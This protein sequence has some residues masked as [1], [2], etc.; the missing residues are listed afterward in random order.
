VAHQEAQVQVDLQEQ[1]EV[2]VHQEHQVL[3]GHQEQVE[4]LDHQEHQEQVVL[5]EHP[6]VVVRQGLLVH[7]EQVG[8]HFLQ[9]ELVLLILIILLPVQQIKQYTIQVYQQEEL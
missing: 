2:Q 1:V 6:V 3:V 4:V 7:L 9:Q 8:H 5:Q